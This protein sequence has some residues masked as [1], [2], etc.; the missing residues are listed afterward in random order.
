MLEPS[1]VL[2]DIKKFKERPDSK[3][4]VNLLLSATPGRNT[5]TFHEQLYVSG[6]KKNKTNKINKKG[7]PITEVTRLLPC[8]LSFLTSTQIC[9]HRPP[10]LV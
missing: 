1:T 6:K 2:Q 8:F 4:K 10:F 5:K 3:W 7:T 9:R